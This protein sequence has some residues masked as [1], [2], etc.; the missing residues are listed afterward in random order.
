MMDSAN[1][2][3]LETTS[4][5]LAITASPEV[6]ATLVQSLISSPDRTIR[7]SILLPFLS[8]PALS[9]LNLSQNPPGEP[10]PGFNGSMS[11]TLGFIGLLG[12]LLVVS[13]LTDRYLKN[14]PESINYKR[15]T[16]GFI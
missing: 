15:I 7:L 9:V 16:G 14:R 12:A 13:T 2:V 4:N 3:V 1:T 10:I 11:F 5:T 6:D 8:A